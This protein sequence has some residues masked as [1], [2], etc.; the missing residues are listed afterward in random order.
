MEWRSFWRKQKLWKCVN[1]EEERTLIGRIEDIHVM[2][3]FGEWR[4]WLKHRKNRTVNAEIREAF[5]RRNELVS[6][7]KM[8]L[9]LYSCSVTCCS[10]MD[11]GHTEVTQ[12]LE[13]FTMWIWCRL[14]IYYECRQSAQCTTKKYHGTMLII[15]HENISLFSNRLIC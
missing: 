12:K 4:L 3:T 11:R 8:W 5:S 10:D 15:L 13:A 7:R 2:Y 1:P 9:E 14:L 6:I